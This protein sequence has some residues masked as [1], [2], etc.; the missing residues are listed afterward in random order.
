MRKF[1]SDLL[2]WIPRNPARMPKMAM[3]KNITA[4]MRGKN[5]GIFAIIT[6]IN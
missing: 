3:K 5:V 4:A 1:G 2:F 6:S